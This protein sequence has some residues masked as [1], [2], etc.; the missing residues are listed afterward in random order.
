[1]RYP[2]VFIVLCALGVLVILGSDL[3]VP[4]LPL[5]ARELG[6][7]PI[8]IGFIRSSYFLTRIF[9]ELPIGV[10]SDR[11]GR[12]KPIILGLLL[13]AVS[14]I[15]CAT[16][17]NI[18]QL[19]AGRALWGV[20]GALY[21]ATSTVFVLDI[22]QK[23]KGKAL[24]IF[25]GVEF[26]GR[27]VGSPVGGA[28][29]EYFGFRAAFSATGVALLGGLALALF[30]KDFKNPES[31]T[32]RTE[33]LGVLAS[34]T[35]LRNWPIM[36]ASLVGFLRTFNMQGITQTLIPLFQ[37]YELGFG[38]FEIGLLASL[39]TVGVVAMTLLGGLLTDK[40]GRN[41]I[42]IGGIVATAIANITY[43]MFPAFEGQA[44]VSVLAGLGAGMMTVVLP[45]IVSE[46]VDASARG[47][48][49]GAYRTV[50]DVGSVIGPIAATMGLTLP[51]ENVEGGLGD[52]SGRFYLFTAALAIGIP[53]VLTLRRSEKSQATKNTDSP[54]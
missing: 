40:I 9:V 24:G 53:L 35:L 31:K 29:S 41:P 16:S 48:A 42:L 43:L 50:F 2:R 14:A 36:V 45:L 37:A 25:Q 5:F 54:E 18:W 23:D 39:R 4:M 21:F 51:E 8:E 15:I 52:I 12:R 19:I 38:P 32:V 28:L 22:F 20:G 6:A 47:S 34:L 26:A 1:M 46:A 10:I 7:T 13:S 17:P 3:A 49:M 30:S 11:V 27:F 33:Q 44:V